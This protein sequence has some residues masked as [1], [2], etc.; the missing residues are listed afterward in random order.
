METCH[1]NEI[2]QI[3]QMYQLSTLNT[4]TCS[5]SINCTVHFSYMP[6]NNNRES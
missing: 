2:Q 5:L 6:R 1:T 4:S 3:I